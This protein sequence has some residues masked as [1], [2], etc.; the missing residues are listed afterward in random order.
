MRREW[1]SE[2]PYRLGVMLS[3]F[4]NP[5][6]VRIFR[7]AG[8]Q[9][10]IIDDEHGYF[11]YSKVAALISTAAGYGY[12]VMI[13]VPGISR[14]YIT[15]VLDMG[16]SGILVPM[17][18]TPEDAAQIVSYAKYS[19]IGHRGVSTMRAHTDYAPPS[20]PFYMKE[21]NQR[22]SVFI[23]IETQRAL[24]NAKEIASV[25]GL[26]GLFIGPNDLS[27]DMGLPG[28][29]SSDEILDAAAQI[30]EAVAACDKVLGVVTSN[31]ILIR[32]CMQLGYSMFSYGSELDLLMRAAK[33]R[34]A[35]F[36][37]LY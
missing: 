18:N 11:D 25:E 22:V 29:V 13:R 10:V 16:A 19:P 33:Q 36:K 17:V 23:Q 4:E 30:K 12:P 15:K 35:Y 21:A 9:F 8:F 31:E 26:D 27:C 34:A 24:R 37:E 14:E 5:N 7:Q 6:L 3:E 28:G 2:E 1:F 20:L 32:H